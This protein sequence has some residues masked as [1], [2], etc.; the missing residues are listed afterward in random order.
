MKTKFKINAFWKIYNVKEILIYSYFT[1]YLVEIKRNEYKIWHEKGLNMSA[2]SWTK[3]TIEELKKVC[4]ANINLINKKD[5]D[6][7][8]KMFTE[9]AKTS[10]I[11]RLD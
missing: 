4:E 1:F 9:Q 6:Y 10:N 7:L 2:I 3:D 8:N 5:R 11:S